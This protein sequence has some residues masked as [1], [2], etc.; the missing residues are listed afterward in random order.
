MVTWDG[1]VVP[2]CFDFDA[3]VVL[4]DLK[5]Q[6]MEEIW[7]GPAYIE[8]RKA[9]LEGRNRSE[10]CANCNQAPGHAPVLDFPEH[11]SVAALPERQQAN[12]K[13]DLSWR[14]KLRQFK[15]KIF[16]S[17]KEAVPSDF[18]SDHSGADVEPLREGG[19]HQHDHL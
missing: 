17:G 18:L 9:E 13:L 8:L 1:R 3:K 15:A 12:K 6:T 5:T 16:S 4:G 10:L 2:C 14:I 19:P 7:N 11:A